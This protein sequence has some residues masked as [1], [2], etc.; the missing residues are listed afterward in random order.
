MFKLRLDNRVIWINDIL[1]SQEELQSHF[2]GADF[3][4]QLCI[5]QHPLQKQLHQ[6]STNSIRLVTVRSLKDGQI[7]A[8]SSILRIGTGSSVVDNTSQGGIAVGFDLQTGQLHEFGLYKPQFGA[9]VSV[10]PDSGIHFSCYCIPYIREAIEQAKYFHSFLNLH[11]IGWD[12]AIGE[13][14]PI[15]I[16]GNDN[17]EINGPQS[18]NHGLA[19]EFKELFYK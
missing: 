5:T 1:A 17:W 6:Q 10:H 9:R 8:L 7:V 13:K 16:E 15:F 18:C 12:I 2:S 3:L 4:V 19:K 11:S 14:G